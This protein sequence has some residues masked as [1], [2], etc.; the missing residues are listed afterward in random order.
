MYSTLVNSG[1]PVSS[2]C[3]LALAPINGRK[4]HFWRCL[5]YLH[6]RIRRI[7]DVPKSTLQPRVIALCSLNFISVD[8]NDIRALEFDIT[9]KTRTRRREFMYTSAVCEPQRIKPGISQSSGL[10]I[11]S[12]SQQFIT[13]ERIMWQP[14]PDNS[15]VNYLNRVLSSFITTCLSLVHQTQRMMKYLSRNSDKCKSSVTVSR[16]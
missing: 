8:R 16:P 10:A 5:L 14:P 1:Q 6:S 11:L 15:T 2:L 7:L 3:D 4:P 13:L 12:D 9:G